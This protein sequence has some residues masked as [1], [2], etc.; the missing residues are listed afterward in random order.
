MWHQ[1]LLFYCSKGATDTTPV[2]MDLEPET[3][4]HHNPAAPTTV[5]AAATPAV[6]QVDL[7]HELREFLEGGTNLPQTEDPAIEHML[8]E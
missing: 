4:V 1:S 6:T 7:E 3:I 8:M 2:P 5:P